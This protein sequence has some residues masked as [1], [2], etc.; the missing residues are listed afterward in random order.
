MSTRKVYRFFLIA[1]R[2]FSQMMLNA[3]PP[4]LFR[5]FPGPTDLS[6]DQFPE[7]D[8]LSFDMKCIDRPDAPRHTYA[9]IFRGKAAFDLCCK[10][11]EQVARDLYGQ[12]K[13]PKELKVF[14]SFSNPSAT[15]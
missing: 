2:E 7:N 11:F 1:D 12:S 8:V 15:T 9:G 3:M 10:A 14:A 13:E 5:V 6:K 4:E